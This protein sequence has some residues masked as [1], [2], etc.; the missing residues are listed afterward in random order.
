MIVM[1]KILNVKQRRSIPGNHHPPRD[2]F[3]YAAG[4]AHHDMVE[5][6]RVEFTI[7]AAGSSPRTE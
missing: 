3:D 2:G 5:R 1:R 7:G 4:A 6:L